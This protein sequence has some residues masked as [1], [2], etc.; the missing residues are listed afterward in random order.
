MTVARVSIVEQSSED[1]I[2]SLKDLYTD[3][4][5]KNFPTAQRSWVAQTSPTSSFTFTI[6]LNQDEAGSTSSGRR[7]YQNLPKKN[8][9]MILHMWD[10]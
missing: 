10:Q 9:Y 1:N 5:E 4:R 6:Y 3:N 8:L 2:Y 7:D